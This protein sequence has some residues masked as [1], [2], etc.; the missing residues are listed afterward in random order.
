[1]LQQAGRS[2][3]ASIVGEGPQRSTFETLAKAHGLERAIR[4]TGAK[5]ARSAFALGRVL[6]VPSRAESLPY[7]VLEGAAAGMPI[8]ATAVGGIG[9]IFG[10]DAGALVPAGDANALARAIDRALE[11][12]QTAATLA[13]NLQAR[14]RANFSV[15]V[16]TEAV[17]AAYGEA[18][19][20]PHG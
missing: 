19:A 13:Q 20:Q 15:D 8:V 1:M 16:M 2:I 11:D 3:T 18:L 7:I 5:P 6:V 4:F 10:A 17:L 14:V 12:T 9:E